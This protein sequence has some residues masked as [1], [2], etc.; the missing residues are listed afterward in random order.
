ML[1]RTVPAL[2]D[3]RVWNGTRDADLIAWMGDRA[4]RFDDDGQ[5]VILTTD[6]EIRPRPGWTLVSW[7]DG[8][9]TVMSARAALIRLTPVPTCPRCDESLTGGED[10]CA[11]LTGDD[12]PYCSSECVVATWH[13]LTKNRPHTPDNGTDT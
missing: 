13:A 10:E 8:A 12:R 4:H 3:T 11:Y 9:L 6:G 2:V 1:Q 7:P 5:L